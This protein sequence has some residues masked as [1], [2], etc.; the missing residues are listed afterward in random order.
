MFICLFICLFVCPLTVFF[1]FCPSLTDVDVALSLWEPI[2]KDRFKF[3]NEWLSFIR[4]LDPESNNNSSNNKLSLK[5]ISL[6]IWLIVIDLAAA[7]DN[8][9]N[10]EDDG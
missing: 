3:L 8:E 5:A 7:M 9:G 6:D 10:Y 1:Y 4:S 2:L